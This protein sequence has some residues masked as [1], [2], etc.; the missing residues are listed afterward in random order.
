MVK[1]CLDF[2]S[3]K[4]VYFLFALELGTEFHGRYLSLLLLILVCL[5]GI[6]SISK[7]M[8]IEFLMISFVISGNTIF[9][10]DMFMDFN[11]PVFLIN[12]VCKKNMLKIINIQ[13]YEK[14][15]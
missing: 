13:K 15:K 6:F 14:V 7:I 4:L 9:V 5:H 10:E 1:I 11:F 3:E 2:T 8:I 12:T